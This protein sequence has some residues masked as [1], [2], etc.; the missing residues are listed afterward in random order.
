MDA[1][2]RERFLR[3]IGIFTEEQLLK[4]KSTRVAIG[5]LGL[6]GTVFL[7]LV[8]MG[9]ENFH[10]ADPDIFERT[11][12]NRQ[13]LAKETTIGL[14]KD[15]CSLA[16]A[17]AINPNVNVR[18]FREGVKPSNL[19][20][21]LSGVDWVVDVVDVFAMEDKLAL[22]TEAHRR[23][24]PVAS[25]ATLGFSGSVVIFNKDTPSFA[26]LTGI[27]TENSYEENLSRFLRFICPE[28][29]DYMWGQLVKALDRSGYVPFVTPGG[30]ISAA[31][32]ASE[33]AKNIVGLGKTVI[34]P[35][36]VFV[37][38]AQVRTEIFEANFRTRSLHIPEKEYKKAA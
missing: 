10:I 19:N 22:N 23:G 30:E 16:E 18:L 24:L 12:I 36:G 27:S 29:P 6:G 5:G 4:L 17:R 26:N 32:T 8:R 21:F 35:Y 14:R 34:A 31:I 7:N 20:K 28:V 38:A 13:R 37:D 3:S 11:N 1:S 33:I 15:D 9:I 25:C 2:Y